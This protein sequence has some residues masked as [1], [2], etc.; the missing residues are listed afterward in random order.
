MADGE[1]RHR[2]LGFSSVFRVYMRC[3]GSLLAFKYEKTVRVMTVRLLV[4][5]P[6]PR[7]TDPLGPECGVKRSA[8]SRAFPWLYRAFI[9]IWGAEVLETVC[10]ECFLESSNLVYEHPLSRA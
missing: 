2:G 6:G 5:G 10:Q 4:T 7:A 1:L 3:V 8:R 9:I